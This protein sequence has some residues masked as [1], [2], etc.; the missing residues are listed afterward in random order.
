MLK[1]WNYEEAIQK[2]E[3]IKALGLDDDIY[4][5]V[6]PYPW[7]IATSCEPGGSHRL[8]IATS[9]WFRGE[10]DGLKFRWSFDIEPH[11]REANGQGSYQINTEG[12]LEV[13]GHL[14]GKC[15]T[16]FKLY[17]KDCAEKILKVAD[18][19]Q[20]IAYKQYRDAVILRSL[21]SKRKE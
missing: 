17:L 3:H 21:I 7:H 10:S 11:S 8:E 6:G 14:K 15:L 13:I 2:A 12:C 20:Q 9:V 1:T 16:Q 18:E 5:S 19:Y 4:L